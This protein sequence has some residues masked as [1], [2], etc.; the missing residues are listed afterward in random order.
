M[1]GVK[2][3][4]GKAAE[5]AVRQAVLRL[6]KPPYVFAWYPSD[7]YYAVDGF[8]VSGNDIVALFECKIRDAVFQNGEIVFKGKGFDSLIL[9]EDKII[10]GVSMAK[11]M[12]LDFYLIAYLSK[13]R[14]YL[15]YKLYDVQSDKVM[16]YASKSTWTQ[17]NVN[18][19]EAYRKN[20]FLSVSSAKVVK[21]ESKES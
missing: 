14:H 10:S 13:S 1:L 19:G 8:I 9:S 21:D 16:S 20:A 18:G 4:K 17:E 7:N 11:Q 12:R 2:T 6:Q 3:E 15:I 5:Q